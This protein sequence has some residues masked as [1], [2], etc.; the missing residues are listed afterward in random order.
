MMLSLYYSSQWAAIMLWNCYGSHGYKRAFPNQISLEKRKLTSGI[1]EQF[2]WVWLC[3]CDGWCGL[4]TL[5]PRIHGGNRVTA[6]SPSHPQPYTNAMPLL[7][8][9][10][11]INYH[12][13]ENRQQ[14]LQYIAL[15]YA[16]ILLVSF[17][18]AAYFIN[19]ISIYGNTTQVHHV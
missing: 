19:R 3:F 5:T 15:L 17:D 6:L 14:V 7:V 18:N 13:T 8:R 12:R 9:S 10:A 11:D 2:H 16:Y 4:D 1:W